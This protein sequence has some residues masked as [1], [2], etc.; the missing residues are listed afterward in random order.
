M[1]V[2]LTESLVFSR[3]NRRLRFSKRQLMEEQVI[4]AHIGALIKTR[5]K[6]F[7]LTQEKLASQLFISRASLANIETG[8][9]KI[10]VH[11]LYGLAAALDMP[12]ADFLPVVE[13]SQAVKKTTALPLPSGL[14]PQQ[15][16][17]IERVFASPNPKSSKLT[18]E[19]NGKQTK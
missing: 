15:K 12:P 13:Q 7:K 4:Y 17:Q 19:D 10:L 6:H 8:R 18:G 9:Q 11:L 2:T 1:F 3:N 16:V 5:R 14:N